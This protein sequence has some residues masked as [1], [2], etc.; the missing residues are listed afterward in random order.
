MTTVDITTTNTDP[1][2]AVHPLTGEALDVRSL[3]GAGLADAIEDVNNLYGILATF[4]RTIVDEVARRADE[5][6]ERKTMIDGV[7]FEV[8]APTTDEYELENLRAVLDPLVAEG[9][10]PQATVDAIIVRQEPKAPPPKIDKRKIN[11]FL[12]GEDRTLLAA[13][14]QARTRAVNT[15]TARIISRPVDVTGEEVHD[16]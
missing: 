11:A 2:V 12:K 10:I 4:K 5:V 3:D 14:A 16:G 6:A 8:N 1:V 13:L 9:K 15:R 7:T